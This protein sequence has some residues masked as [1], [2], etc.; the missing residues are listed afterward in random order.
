MTD[1]QDY[2]AAE[3]LEIIQSD[4]SKKNEKWFNN[5]L[6]KFSLKFLEYTENL[7]EEEKNNLKTKLRNLIK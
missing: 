5:A 7:N 3:W 4:S 2:L 1:W 6:R